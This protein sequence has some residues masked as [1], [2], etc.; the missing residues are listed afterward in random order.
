MLPA[1]GKRPCF[2]LVL[3][4]PCGRGPL[5][6]VAWTPGLGRT[7]RGWPA[8]QTP[9]QSSPSERASPLLEALSWGARHRQNQQRHDQP[10]CC[11]CSHLSNE[12]TGLQGTPAQGRAR[13]RERA[14]D[15]SAGREVLRL[16]TV[17]RAPKEDRKMLRLAQR[18]RAGEGRLP[19]GGA[20]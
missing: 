19:G 20:A 11:V 13:P 6:A 12:G 3:L 16:N 18:V 15:G 9:L 10:L 17:Q 7:W 14:G 4:H 1:P 5:R 2:I 8:S